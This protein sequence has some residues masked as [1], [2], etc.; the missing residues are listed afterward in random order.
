MSSAPG[1]LPRKAIS[2]MVVHA[3]NQKG[4]TIGEI[5]SAKSKK[6]KGDESQEPYR[7]SPKWHY[8]QELIMFV[9]E[10]LK[11]HSSYIGQKRTS[12]DFHNAI[13]QEITK[14]RSKKLVEEWNSKK[15]SGIWCVVKQ[16]SVIDPQMSIEIGSTTQT[17]TFQGEYDLKH[18]F[19]SILTKGSKNNTYKFTLA[20]SLL[21]YCSENP[22]YNSQTC[23]IPYKYFASKFLKYYWYQEYRF[24]MKQDF[25][26]KRRPKV[27]TVLNDVFGK[28]P[29]PVFG[30]L[31][32]GKIE[33][34]TNKIISHVFGHARSKT[35]LVIPKFQK[36]P[37]GKT[38]QEYRVF[39]DY[40][41]DKKILTLKPEAFI[42]FKQNYGI[43]S[44]VVLAEWA[45]FLEKINHTLPRLVAKIEEG[46][47]ER[48]SL[49][50]YHKIFLPYEDHCFYCMGKLER[51][52]IHVDHFIPWSYIFDDDAWNLVLACQTCNLRKSASL[53]QE[54]FL[55]L[56][57]KRNK[58]YYDRIGKLKLSLDQ[59][60]TGKGWKP[61]IKNHY[62]NCLEY[63]FNSIRLP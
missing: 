51:G 26:V 41:D 38:T 46:D 57:V 35:S 62:T 22:E 63:G 53:P 19:L 28:N 33:K 34:A 25:H 31:D 29:P 42:F 52:Y 56:L 10:K 5:E 11:I 12:N 24:R 27:I 2:D 6:Y 47:P 50:E 7:D 36:I 58:T 32:E 43:L 45:K 15:R 48:G 23:K 16:L 49:A 54:N 4:N 30:Q 55:D 9:A 44:K 37:V 21:D 61:E 13:D 20:K 18:K 14:L 40:D 1:V 8:R 3:L 39:Y 60:N 17:E 59:L